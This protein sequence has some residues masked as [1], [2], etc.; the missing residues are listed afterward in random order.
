MSLIQKEAIKIFLLS[1]L[2]MTVV[3][4]FSYWYPR[5]LVSYLG[6]DSPWISYLY[7]YGM[8]FVFF[9]LSVWFIFTKKGVN[10]H[11][12]RQEIYWLIAIFFGMACT[13][14]LHSLWIFLAITLPFR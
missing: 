14:F 1:F 10:P 6:E 7:T 9:V 12:R 11:R 2:L 3:F 13:Y 8:G 4:V 5:M